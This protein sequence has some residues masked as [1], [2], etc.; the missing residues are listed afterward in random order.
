MV[1]RIH[2]SEIRS[3]ES[4]RRR[5]D[6]HY[7]QRFMPVRPI[8]YLEFGTAY[9]KAMEVFHDPERWHY[10]IDV[11][12]A[13]AIK[14]FIDTCDEQKNAYRDHVGSLDQS[15]EDDYAERLELGQGMLAHYAY[16]IF[17]K[18]MASYKPIMVE[19]PFEIPVTVNGE[20]LQCPY[21]DGS[22]GQDHK[23]DNTIIYGGRVDMIVEDMDEGGYWIWDWKTAAALL[24]DIQSKY[25]EIDPQVGSYPWALRLKLGIN[26]RGFIYYEQRKEFPHPPRELKRQT[27]GCWYSQNKSQITDYPT[28]LNHVSENDPDAFNAGLYDEILD[29]FANNEE[30]FYKIHRVMKNDHQLLETGRMISQIAQEIIEKD[31][32]IYPH[33]GRFNCATC[34]FFDPC[35]A[36]FRGDDWEYALNTIFEE[37]DPYGYAR[38]TTDNY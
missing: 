8:K 2:T 38:P 22:C 19:V 23:G 1:H 5:W 11:K 9:H 25:L 3:F 31:L 26:I 32:R 18:Q 20:V 14:A 7:R 34:A 10:P 27:G 36:K 6:W 28:Y 15:M 12:Y 37:G 4:C 33:P 35:L 29:H 24:G 17:P 30:R 13:M 16:T 21:T